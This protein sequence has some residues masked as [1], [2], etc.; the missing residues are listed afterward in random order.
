MISKLSLRWETDPRSTS[1]STDPLNRNEL[2]L[3]VPDLHV[4]YHEERQ[5]RDRGVVEFVGRKAVPESLKIGP[6]V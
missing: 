6:C 4:L 1:A 3:L 5:V 2:P